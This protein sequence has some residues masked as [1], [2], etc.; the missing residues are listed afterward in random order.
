MNVYNEGRQKGATFFEIVPSSPSRNKFVL[1]TEGSSMHEH[2]HLWK[3]TLILLVL[4]H[5][6]QFCMYMCGGSQPDFVSSVWAPDHYARFCNSCMV[7]MALRP[8]FKPSSTPT[9]LKAKLYSIRHSDSFCFCAV[10]PVSSR[11]F[12]MLVWCWFH[13]LR[14]VRS[15]FEGELG[16]VSCWFRSSFR[17]LFKGLSVIDECMMSC[18]NAFMIQPSI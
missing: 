18:T 13:C 4:D 5:D 15:Q 8:S 3:S 1:N 7:A 16:L 9:H 17:R 10:W 2:I 11:W 6:A 12:D 14:L